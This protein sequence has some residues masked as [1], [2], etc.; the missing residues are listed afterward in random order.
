MKPTVKMK[1]CWFLSSKKNTFLLLMMFLTGT[2]SLGHAAGPGVLALLPDD[3][4]STHT[5]HGLTYTAT[6]GTLPLFDDQG[7]RLASVF[8]TAYVRQDAPTVRPLTFVFNGGPGA[9]SAYVHLGLVGTRLLQFCAGGRDGADAVLRDNPQSWLDFTDLVIIDP[10]GTGWSRTVNPNDTA[11][12][13]G[14][15]ENANEVGYA[16]C[17]EMEPGDIF[18]IATPGAG[19]H[20]AAPPLALS[21]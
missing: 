11:Q 2:V 6:A 5:V 1:V 4:V 8:Y 14:V 20:G 16:D 9:A 3:A 10:I 19:G 21:V 13:W 12:F 17:V 7:A 18:R 15:R